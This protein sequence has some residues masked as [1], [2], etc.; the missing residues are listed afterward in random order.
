MNIPWETTTLGSSNN[1]FFK[2][3][4]YAMPIEEG[5]G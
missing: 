1:L 3:E 4:G 5:L 2:I